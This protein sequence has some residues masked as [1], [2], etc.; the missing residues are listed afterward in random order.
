VE[1]IRCLFYICPKQVV[2]V[3]MNIMKKTIYIILT[4]FLGLLLSFILH[5]LVEL[6]YI[7]IMLARGLEVQGSY[8]LGVGWCALPIWVQYTFPAMGI[9]GGYFLG[10]TWWRIVYVEHRH[11]RFA[12]N[13]KNKTKK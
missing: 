3:I 10:K 7:N 13:K 12:K 1:K 8:F 2:S 9:I 6:V 11:W 4:I 5:A